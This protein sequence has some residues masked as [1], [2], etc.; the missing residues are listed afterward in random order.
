MSLTA[1]FI[2]KAMQFIF[3]NDPNQRLLEAH[4]KPNG[5]FYQ[6][7]DENYRVEMRI[8]VTKIGE[9]NNG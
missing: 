8:R 2:Q 1:I 7:Q 5:K 4:M 9:D 6:F 3:G